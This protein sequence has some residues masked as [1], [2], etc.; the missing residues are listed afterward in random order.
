MVIYLVF[1]AVDVLIRV[2]AG[3]LVLL[4]VGRLI[5]LDLDRLLLLLV[6]EVQHALLREEVLEFSGSVWAVLLG[7]CRDHAL[8][9]S[10]RAVLPHDTHVGELV[11][12]A[13][14]DVARL[15]ADDAW[16]VLI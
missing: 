16:V 9:V 11:H 13:D 4:D 10:I 3:R 12:L 6:L 7:S 5:E 2:V 1:R 14:L 15:K 8:D